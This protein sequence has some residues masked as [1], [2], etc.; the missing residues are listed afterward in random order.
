MVVPMQPWMEIARHGH[1]RGGWEGCPLLN[2]MIVIDIDAG[3]N[4]KNCAPVQYPRE[5]ALRLFHERSVL[6]STAVR[7][8]SSE[9]GGIDSRGSA[10]ETNV[11]GFSRG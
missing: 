5:C 6:E 8:V 11:M 7:A 4:G 1:M 10:A 2:V 3:E 9:R